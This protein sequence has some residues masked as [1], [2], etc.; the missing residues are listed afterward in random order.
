MSIA[1]QIES[2]IEASQ[3]RTIFL[4]L[5]MAHNIS[6]T[7]KLELS[8]SCKGL[9]NLDK[10]SKSDPMAVVFQKGSGSNTFM[11]VGRTEMISD[12]LVQLLHL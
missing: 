8:I 3:S 5:P 10:L 9:R 11:E 12:N 2:A 4:C 6:P 1:C 7:S